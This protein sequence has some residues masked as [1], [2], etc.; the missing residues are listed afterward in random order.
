MPYTKYIPFEEIAPGWPDH[1]FSAPP[2]G[3]LAIVG[4]EVTEGA[5]GSTAW[6][7]L[8]VASDL[9]FSLAGLD[10][11]ELV[12][13]GDPTN[14]LRVTVALAGPFQATVEGFD[15]TLMIQSDLLVPVTGGPG[16][17]VPD[18]SGQLTATMNIGTLVID[19]SFQ[20]R[21]ELDTS[22]SLGAFM[23]GDTGLVVET[24]GIRPVFSANEPPPPGLPPGFRGVAIES[25]KIHLPDAFS[26][27]ELA[28]DSI[29]ITG[30]AIGNGGISGAISGAWQPA[31][32]DGTPT[33]SGSG[34][35]IGIPF[36]LRSLGV[37]LTQ[38]AISGAQLSGE[39]LIPFFEELVS[40][41][42]QIG[43]DG[44]FLV[45]VS[46]PSGQ[47]GPIRIQ[48]DG[49]GTLEIT[50]LGIVRD[51][52]GDALLLSGTLDLELG[53]PTLAW[54]TIAFQDLRIGADGKVQI[55]GGWIDLQQPI[56]LDL[57]GF[58]MEITRIGFGNEEDGRRWIGVDGAVRLTELLPA[59]A[60]ARG[61]RVI[62]DPAHPGALPQ[63]ALD[64]IGVSFG[65]PDAFAFEGEVALAADPEDP[66][67]R[68]FTGSLGLGLDA[69]DVGV[70]ADIT[71]GRQPPHTYVY[72]HLG[73][74]VPI[75]IAATGAA[76]YGMEALFAMN[77]SPSATSGDW[78]SWYK[79]PDPFSVTDPTK[80]TPQ[81]GAWAFG[82]GL[83]LG[84]LPDAGFSVNT[85]ALLVVLLPG[86]VILLDGKADIFKVPAALGDA[87]QESTLSLLAASTGVL[88]RCSSG[89]TRPGA[90]PASSRSPPAPRPSST[91]TAATRGTSGS[92]RTRRRAHASAPTTSRC[93]TR[94]PG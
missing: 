77:M 65:I 5:N 6:V 24:T 86:P 32:I 26:L 78:Y 29:E 52:D 57:Y 33:G 87:T 7:D 73:V 36:A 70:N 79:S 51:S 90:W 59:G 56:A 84:T 8:A 27:A 71:I 10:G 58:G 91:S 34:T 75:P 63:L 44:G 3:T 66:D 53:S 11:V 1:L 20:P 42:V 39:L 55:P 30:L 9:T 25:A 72:V 31:W 2:T 69:L 48:M 14:P 16:S 76:L 74:N 23:I 37:T 92:A 62:W 54:P 61:L 93:S 49:I 28:P 89:S 47:A 41:S 82:G 88:E 64:G 94:T 38:N 13:P 21:F 85:K 68:L 35:F 12:L 80:W 67:L 43:A 40:V 83:S 17:W 45:E 19:D 60:S 50:S 81:V 15:A 46:V 22:V 4:Y 18:A